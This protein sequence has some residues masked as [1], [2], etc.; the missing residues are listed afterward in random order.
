MFVCSFVHSFIARAHP[1]PRARAQE[2]IL[3]PKVK[4]RPHPRVELSQVEKEEWELRRPTSASHPTTFQARHLKTNKTY[5]NKP[6]TVDLSLKAPA[7]RQGVNH[8][9]VPRAIRWLANPR[10]TDDSQTMVEPVWIQLFRSVLS[11]K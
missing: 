8:A 9:G 6:T 2:F 11:Y 1:V 7:P 4:R 10:W 5:L 3:R